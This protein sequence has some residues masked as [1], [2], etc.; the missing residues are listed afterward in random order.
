MLTTAGAGEERED[1]GGPARRSTALRAGALAAAVDPSREER[2][3]GAE[4]V[5]VG[6][7]TSWE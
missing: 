4:V 2:G 3:A 7:A 6:G 5:A 1:D